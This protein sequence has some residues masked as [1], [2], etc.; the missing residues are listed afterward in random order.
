MGYMVD[1]RGDG[2]GEFLDVGFWGGGVGCDSGIW[3]FVNMTEGNGAFGLSI[4]VTFR[5][6]DDQ[7]PRLRLKC[8]TSTLHQRPLHP[9]TTEPTLISHL[10]HPLS[11]T[12]SSLLSF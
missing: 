8:I 9:T 12:F 5:L 11:A 2:N 1:D 7:I 10:T 4:G 3:E 6:S